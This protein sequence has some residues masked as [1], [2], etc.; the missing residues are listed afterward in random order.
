MRLFIGE[1]LGGGD[2]LAMRE[3]RG[4]TVCISL[5]SSPGS[6]TQELGGVDRGP[7]FPRREPTYRNL[8]TYLLGLS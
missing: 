2:F 8:A 7:L 5:S 1:L 3:V 4:I 6:V